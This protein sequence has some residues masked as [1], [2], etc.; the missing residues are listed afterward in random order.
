M[1]SRKPDTRATMLTCRELSVCAT[2]VGVNGIVVG[3][4][5][6]TVTSGGG[7]GG[8]G[9]SFE[10]PAAAAAT[11]HTA[12]WRA[13]RKRMPWNRF[14]GLCVLGRKKR[15][16]RRGSADDSVRF[17]PHLPRFVDRSDARPTAGAR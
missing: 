15:R 7:R 11:E 3:V 5:V 4:T 8:G 10:Q 16:N 12:R 2:N 1:R 13:K 9:A 6:T 14:I 17:L